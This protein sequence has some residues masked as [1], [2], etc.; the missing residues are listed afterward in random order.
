MQCIIATNL[1]MILGDAVNVSSFASND[2]AMKPHWGRNLGNHDTVSLKN[3]TRKLCNV[4]ME[5][6]L[7]DD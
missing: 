5:I 6:L 7:K 1:G 3:K 2:E 4:C